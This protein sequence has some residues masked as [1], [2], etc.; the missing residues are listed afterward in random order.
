[1][2]DGI[3]FLMFKVYGMYWKEMLPILNGYNTGIVKIPF[4]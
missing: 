4:H 3:C 1:V 2:L